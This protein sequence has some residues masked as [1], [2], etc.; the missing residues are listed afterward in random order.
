M[1][2]N[3]NEII[4]NIKDILIE[5]SDLGHSVNVRPIYNPHINIIN[6]EIIINFRK[7][8]NIN[9]ELH[10]DLVSLQLFLNKKGYLGYTFKYKDINKW[11]RFYIYDDDRKLRNGDIHKMERWLPVYRIVL[12]FI[13]KIPNNE[14]KNESK[15][16]R[17]NSF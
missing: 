17:F 7:P 16:K 2:E 15:I 4:L 10:N 12:N 1:E 14:I 11:N 9:N 5:L 6:I 3:V 8:I 13:K